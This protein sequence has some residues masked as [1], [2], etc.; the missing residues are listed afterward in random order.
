MKI[1]NVRIEPAIMNAACSV[2][3][4]VD[5]VTALSKTN[6]GAI[7]VG[8][9]TVLP[10]QGNST[11]RWYHA[12]DYALNSFGMP[13]EGITFYKEHLPE[14]IKITHSSKKKFILSIAGFST[15]EYVQLAQLADNAKVDIIEL[16][17]GCPN[18]SIDGK[19]KPIA[20]FDTVTIGEIIDAVSASTDIPLTVKLSPY[21]NPSEL[22]KVAEV[23]A[24]SGKVSGVVS[25]NTFPNS[26][27]FDNDTS[28]LATGYGG[29]SGKALLPISLGQ[30][31]QFRRVLPESIV[32]IGVGGIETSKDAE[33][34][35]A[36]GASAVQ[37]ATLI[38]R[39]GHSAI[40]KVVSP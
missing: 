26:L 15:K 25:T 35:Y 18:V 14:M 8:S 4:S 32:V 16:N 30:V 34:Y 29:M 22:V 40:S 2:A 20:S 37:V 17:L 38:V 1:G 19:Q 33:L 3:K 6:I 27:M 24:H 23:I 36:A 13:N 5:D 9:I 10:R 39:D 21:S 31:Q 11:P 12:A 7:V 28:V